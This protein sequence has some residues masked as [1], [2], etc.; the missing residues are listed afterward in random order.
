MH[1]R[2]ASRSSSSLAFA[3]ATALLLAAPAL[4][5]ATV[6]SNFDA[7]GVDGWR[8]SEFLFNSAGFGTPT[9][10]ATGGNPGGRLT[11]VDFYDWHAFV[12]GPQFNGDKSAFYGG[13]LSFDLRTDFARFASPNYPAV[14]IYGTNGS[15][16]QGRG[17]YPGSAA[18]YVNFSFALVESAW[19]THVAGSD[20]AGGTP[21]QG[22]FQA[23]LGSIA[24][25]RINADF[26]GGVDAYDLDNVVMS[27]PGGDA[28]VV[29][30]PGALALFVSGLGLAGFVARARRR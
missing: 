15:S 4:Q 12:A 10:V 18:G 24:S 26:Y 14:I 25:I 27:S 6:T 11:T 7:P 13:N 2:P 30:V 8:T 23:I 29:P 20:V 3:F 9:Q 19:Q 17:V 5:A 21:T 1:A 28:T 22:A 16:I